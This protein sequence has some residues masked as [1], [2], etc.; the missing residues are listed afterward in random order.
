[1]GLINKRYLLT[2][3]QRVQGSKSLC[4]HQQNQSLR[5]KILFSPTAKSFRDNIR[6]NKSQIS[7]SGP[8]ETW[9]RSTG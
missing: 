6:D 8:C 7:P 3:N 5:Q 9:S 1:M 2:L 4:A